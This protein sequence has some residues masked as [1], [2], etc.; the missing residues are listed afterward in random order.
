MTLVLV[1][2]FGAV[3]VAAALASLYLKDMVSAIIASGTVSL[4]ASVLYLVFGAP[5]VAMTEA[6][7]G[8]AL[9]TV[10]FL[11]AWNRI[12]KISQSPRKYEPQG[13]EAKEDRE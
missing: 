2:A 3:I 12:K 7:I 11:L 1:I 13:G 5:D 8:S 4:L 6:A 9:T 10:V